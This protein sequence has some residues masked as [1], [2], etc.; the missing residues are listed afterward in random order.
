[1]PPSCRR[2]F[3]NALAAAPPAKESGPALALNALPHA[4][5]AENVRVRRLLTWV[6]PVGLT[7][8]LVTALLYP[9]PGAAVARISLGPFDWAA[10]SVV[11]I[12]FI[13]GYS[14]NLDSVRGSGFARAVSLVLVVNLL[15]FPLGAWIVVRSVDLPLGLVVGIAVMASVPTTV[16]S[17]AVAAI[18]AGGDRTWAVGLT[19]VCVVVGAF[20]APIAVSAILSANVSVPPGPLLL[21]VLAI[22][23]FPLLLGTVVARALA[24]PLPAWASLVPP[25]AVV[26]VV[27]V[28][29]SQSAAT[30]VAAPLRALG[31]VILVAVVGH[32]SL[33]ALGAIASSR[34]PPAQ[35][36]PILFV[37]S[38]K[39]FSLA[40]SVL[41]A[42][43]A[44]DPGLESAMAGA[45]LVGLA[46]H[47]VQI[48]VDGVVAGRR[49]R[50][51]KLRLFR[52]GGRSDR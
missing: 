11:L 43:S 5:M 51:G 46:W 32:A 39:S 21:R 40:L 33:L 38:E 25:L 48:L 42:L 31:Q 52:V 16:S 29:M 47:F 44:E 13:S 12:F 15:V 23:V 24:R 22:A 4:L 7:I 20:T 8:A 9:V 36:W 14:I 28:T 35:R 34:Y 1:M 6:L 27:W 19:V 26:S 30:F 3:R 37:T 49:G 10:L 41:V 2:R 17:A 50:F 45:I 18:V